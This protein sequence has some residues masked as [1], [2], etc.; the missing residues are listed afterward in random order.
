MSRKFDEIWKDR[1]VVKL[2]KYEFYFFESDKR[3]K[4]R[5]FKGDHR[6]IKDIHFK[7]EK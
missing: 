3:I 2:D 1:N 5:V 7:K 6:F 4:L